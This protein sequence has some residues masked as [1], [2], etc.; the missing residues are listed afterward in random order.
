VPFRIT[1][2]GTPSIAGGK[3]QVSNGGGTFPVWRGDG[4]ELF[5]SNR[6]SAALMSAR[7]SITGDHFQSDK[8]QPLFDLDAQPVGNYYAVSRDGQKIY[9]TN[10]GAG[11]RAPFAVTTNWPDLVKK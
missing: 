5:F 10:Y 8:P 3:W 6:S 4:K 1:P 9:I 11:S 2:D 7:L